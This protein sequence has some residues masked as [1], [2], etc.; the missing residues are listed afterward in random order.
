MAEQYR[1]R[2]VDRELAARLESAGAVLIEG[3]RACGKT[4]TGRHHAASEVLLDVDAGLR[5]GAELEPGLVLEGPAPRLIDEWQTVPSIW[6]HVR[7]AV[8]MGVGAGRFILTGSAVPPDDTTRHTGVGRVSRMPMR[9]MS[10]FESGHSTAEMSLG[11]MLHAEPMPARQSRTTVTDLVE[12]VCRGGWPGVVDTPVNDAQRFV[13]DY[14]EE[15]RRTDIRRVD[16]VR[17]DPVLVRRVLQSLARNLATEAA[18]SVIAADAGGNA[19]PLHPET[20]QSYLDALERVFAI[21]DQPAWSA[22]LRSRSRLRRSPKRHFVDP[23][24]AVAALR[25]GPDRLRA[26]PGSFGLFFESLAVRDLRIYAQAHDAEVY[27]YRDNTG[28]EVDA[29]VETAGG[30]W[31]GVEVKLGGERPI[32]EG[33]RNLLRLRDRVDPDRTGPPAALVV[34]VGVGHGYTRPDGVVLAPLTALGP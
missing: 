25:S 28:L 14:L 13:R 17:R 3:P 15:I 2:I 5:R 1:P 19:G 18:I 21:E 20:V 30:A 6:N 10:L 4:A 11:A 7:R 9:P 31:I 29:I 33:V 32:E 24:L 22:H 26:D 34:I 27:H 23:S 8:D 16:G 12:L